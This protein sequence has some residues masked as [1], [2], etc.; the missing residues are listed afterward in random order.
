MYVPRI[1]TVSS[2]ICNELRLCVVAAGLHQSLVQHPS[3]RHRSTIV[4]DTS[5]N[6]R[7]R[8]DSVNG[9]S[10]YRKSLYNNRF[11]SVEYPIVKRARVSS[12]VVK[13]YRNVFVILLM[14]FA[15]LCC[16]RPSLAPNK[17]QLRLKQIVA[18]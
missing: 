10:G 14:M 17:M 13:K 16:D 4:V 9:T 7:I 5:R 15:M 6:A 2:H 18:L 1:N 11:T 3:V 12:A 8:T